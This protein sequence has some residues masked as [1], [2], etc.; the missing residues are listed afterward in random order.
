MAKLDRTQTCTTRARCKAASG[1]KDGHKSWKNLDDLNRCTIAVVVKGRATEDDE[2]VSRIQYAQDRVLN[3]P[4]MAYP[5]V[6]RAQEWHEKQANRLFMQVESLKTQATTCRLE[7]PRRGQKHI[8]KILNG[9]AAQP[10]MHV[11]RPVADEPNGCLEGSI[12]TDPGRLTLSCGGSGRRS[13]MA[14]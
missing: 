1:R 5:A 7:D 13:M 11:A 10:L 12:A 4:E 14:I 6:K 8:S 9:A 3:K 2:A